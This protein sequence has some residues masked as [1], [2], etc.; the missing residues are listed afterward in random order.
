MSDPKKPENQST[1]PEDSLAGEGGGEGVDRQGIEGAGAVEAAESTA[2]TLPTYRVLAEGSLRSGL[3]AA[4]DVRWVAVDVSE[5]VE[6]LRQ[7]W[8]LSPLSAVAL[9]QLLTGA[10]LMH[11]LQLKTPVRL[12][13]AARG[14]GPLGTITAEATVDGRLRGTIS[15]PRAVAPEG[16]G[17]LAVSAALGGGRLVVT[18]HYAYG[19]SYESQVPLDESPASGGLLPPQEEDAGGPADAFQGASTPVVAPATGSDGL[20]R[21]LSVYLQR[22]EQTQSAVLLGVLAKPEGIA[23]AGGLI[24]EALPGTDDDL[25]EALERRLAEVPVSR[26]LEAGGLDAL[27]Q[28]ALGEL[29]LEDLES[30]PLTYSCS[31]EREALRQ[32]LAALPKEDRE[33]IADQPWDEIEVVCSFCAERYLFTP[34]ELDVQPSTTS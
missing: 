18:R 16:Y 6:T 17:P 25:L 26:T 11:R 27:L 20:G 29:E 19:Q 3:A 33:H 12:N 28:A 15:N 30:R 21:H 32:R 9:G 5:I 31:C 7:R 8:D 22:S 10:A 1:V 23:S 14:D 24:L 2:A 13:L 4:G 34:Q